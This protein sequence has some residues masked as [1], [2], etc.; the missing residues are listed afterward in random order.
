MQRIYLQT[1]L[2]LGLALTSGARAACTFVGNFGDGGT[3][4]GCGQNVFLASTGMC[5][6]ASAQTNR[7]VKE[8]QFAAYIRACDTAKFWAMGAAQN[9]GWGLAT[10]AATG[11]NVP[12]CGNATTKPIANEYPASKYIR[13][14]Y[15]LP[16]GVVV[17]V[18]DDFQADAAVRNGCGQFQR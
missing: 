4:V 16:N 5:Y 17:R 10:R 7:R 6:R 9:A 14:L 11:T 15:H 2:C 13:D 18:T 1:M 8:S 12:F 3:A